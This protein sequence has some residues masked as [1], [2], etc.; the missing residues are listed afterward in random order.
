MRER[1]QLRAKDPQYV[2]VATVAWPAYY[3]FLLVDSEQRTV[4][5]RSRLTHK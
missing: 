3:V 2:M 4:Q 1:L 5:I